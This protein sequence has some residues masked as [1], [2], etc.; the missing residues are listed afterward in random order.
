MHPII[1]LSNSA[2]VA[3]LVSLFQ[4]W[5]KGSKSRTITIQL[6]KD[7]IEAGNVSKEELTTLIESWLDRHGR[8]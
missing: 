7:R 6:G 5:I 4:S 2:V 8:K 1:T 3:S